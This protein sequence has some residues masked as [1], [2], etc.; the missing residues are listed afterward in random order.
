MLARG[1]LG[2]LLETSGRNPTVAVKAS[3]STTKVLV[4]S[5]RIY[6]VADVSICTDVELHKFGCGKLTKDQR[7]A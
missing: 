2:R 5:S 7:T 4:D 3:G 1:A 6:G